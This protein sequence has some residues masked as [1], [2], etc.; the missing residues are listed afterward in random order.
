MEKSVGTILEPI[1]AILFAAIIMAGVLAIVP[2]V[3]AIE[4]I[5]STNS[6]CC[7]AQLFEKLLFL[8]PFAN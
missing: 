1:T 5:N 4:P 7:V 3:S 2:A 8:P 6:S